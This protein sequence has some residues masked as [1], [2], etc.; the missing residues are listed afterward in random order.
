M[1]TW[2]PLRKREEPLSTPC[3]VFERSLCLLEH[4]LLR[5]ISWGGGGNIRSCLHLCGSFSHS[6]EFFL[7]VLDIRRH[8]VAVSPPTRPR[9]SV[10]VM[11]PPAFPLPPLWLYGGCHR[12]RSFLEWLRPRLFLLTLSPPGVPRRP[13]Q[14]SSNTA[15][16]QR[17]HRSASS[18]TTFCRHQ[19]SHSRS[20]SVVA[21]TMRM[22]M[23]TVTR[24]PSEGVS[25]YA[26]PL[27]PVLVVFC[28]LSSPFF[29]LSL[30]P[31]WQNV[32]FGDH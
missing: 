23:I 1:F 22:R 18:P 25:S 21:D 3:Q 6:V 32:C 27:S 11:Y 17:R 10:G 26:D 28:F 12:R 9:S 14:S 8:L 15:T 30:P 13:R 29:I 20:F 19:C 24:P 2:T 5:M 31:L 16:E 7:G 4:C